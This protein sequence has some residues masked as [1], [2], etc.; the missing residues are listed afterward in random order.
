MFIP[1][2]FSDCDPTSL[3]DN[4]ETTDFINNNN[5]LEKPFPQT[6]E[7]VLVVRKIDASFL[8]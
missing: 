7:C 5:E 4:W 8:L 2:Y 6:S 1:N 3:P